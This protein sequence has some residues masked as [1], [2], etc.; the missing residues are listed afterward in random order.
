VP[1]INASLNLFGYDGAAWRLEVW[2]DV[3]HLAPE[4]ITQYRAAPA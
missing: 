2:G 3:S 4:E 1:L